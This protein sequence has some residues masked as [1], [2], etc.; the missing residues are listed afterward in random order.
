MPVQIEW[1]K[2]Q[3]KLKWTILNQQRGFAAW[4]IFTSIGSMML[5]FDFGLSG[6]LTA[7]GPFKKQYGEPYPSV[8]GGYLIRAPIQSGWTGV[9][10]VGDIVGIFISGY[11]LDWVGRKHTLGIGAVLTAAGVAVQIG[12]QT[13][14]GF[15]VGRLVNAIGFGIVFLV[16]PVFIGEVCRPEVR[17]TFLCIING[18]IVFGQFLL[19][20]AANFCAKRTDKWSYEI[21]IILQFAFCIV[22]LAGYPFFP[23]SPFYFL[24]KS[25]PE[26]ARRSLNKIH[27]SSDQRLIEAEMVRL[28]EMVNTTRHMQE[29]AGELGPPILQSFKGKNLKRTLTA[30]LMSGAQQLIGS[31]FVLGYIT[32]FMELI[33]VSHFFTVS[34]VLYVIMLLSNISAFFVIEYVGRRKL[35]VYGIIGLTLTE[36]LM[37]IMGC[38]SA[39]GAIWVILV[40]IFLWAIIYQMTVGA[41]GF[42]LASEVP[43]PRLRPATM[44]LVGFSQGATGWLIGFVVPYMINPDA[45]NLGAKVG[46]VFFGL[47]VPLSIAFFFLVPETRGLSFEEI[48]HLYNNKVAPRRFQQIIMVEREREAEQGVMGHGKADAAVVSE[49]E[50]CAPPL[51]Q[52]P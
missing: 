28:Q 22:L 8:A 13:W 24:N 19:A 34:V 20:L 18:S 40:S 33:N 42:A 7:F 16:T 39:S 17:G 47:G 44:S 49:V 23:D 31:A 4:A 2:I 48:D 11:L 41:V 35:L 9:S 21:M 1:E 43:T 46:F 10:T 36:L 15:M 29:L 12:V 14:R 6:T 5:G 27:G 52:G 32:Y 38:V 3:P 45:G 50:K 26:K 37:G 51:G 30:C 25:E